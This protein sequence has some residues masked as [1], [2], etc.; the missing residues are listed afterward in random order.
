VHEDDITDAPYVDLDAPETYA[1][2]YLLMMQPSVSL[3][4]ERIQQI[5]SSPITDAERA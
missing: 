5:L 1:G 2:L 4:P 3:T